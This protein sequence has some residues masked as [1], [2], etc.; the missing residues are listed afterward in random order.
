MRKFEV[1]KM[2]ANMGGADRIIRV[3]AA[4]VVGGLYFAG[5]I[6]GI[7]AVVLGIVAV[8]FLATSF[9]SFCPLYKPFGIST[10]AKG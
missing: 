5:Q 9:I 1:K 10:R 7:V 3:L 6:S 4:F 2:K 8:I